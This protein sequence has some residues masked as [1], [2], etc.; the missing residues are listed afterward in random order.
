[1]AGGHVAASWSRATESSVL[2][3]STGQSILYRGGWQR[4]TAPAA[5]AGGTTVDAEARAA[6]GEL[7][8]GACGRRVLPG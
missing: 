2:D 5:P 3:R 1:M 4:P 6:I 8:R 7:V